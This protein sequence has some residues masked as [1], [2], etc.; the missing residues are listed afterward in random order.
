MSASRRR[1]QLPAAVV[2]SRSE[3]EDQR[4]WT[5]NARLRTDGKRRRSDDSTH[6]HSCVQS[7]PR[8]RPARSR[9][10][11]AR[12]HN[13]PVALPGRTL[14]LR[15][16]PTSGWGSTLRFC[17]PGHPAGYWRFFGGFMRKASII[18]AILFPI[19]ASAAATVSTEQCHHGQSGD[20]VG[21][22]GARVFDLLS[23]G[24]D[25][26]ARPGPRS[27]RPQPRRG[28]RAPMAQAAPIRP[29]RVALL[30]RL[31]GRKQQTRS[32]HWAT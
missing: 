4:T 18:V 14:V 20:V 6:C 30:F 28:S 13:S 3:P 1:K 31:G 9:S 12:C 32:E 16:T 27:H 15:T 22:R 17:L 25:P 26:A 21:T 2:C 11:G 19:A 24:P 7:R 29:G 10:T 8:G 23:M 5:G